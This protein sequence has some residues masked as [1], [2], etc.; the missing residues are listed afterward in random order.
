VTLNTSGIDELFAESGTDTIT[1]TLEVEINQS[2][3]P[4][5]I[6]QSEV[7]VRKDLIT[8]GSAVPAPQA[9]YLT[10]AEIAAGFV[11]SQNNVGFYGTTAI[12]KPANTNVVSALVNL[13]LIANTVTVGVASGGAANA[14][15]D[16][17]GNVS[18]TTRFLADSS[19][20]TSVDWGNRFLTD[21]SP[22][23]SLDWQNRSLKTSTAVTSV[24]WG[25][26]VLK[27]STGAT[28]VNWETGA[29]GSGSTVVTIGGNNVA[30]SGSYYIAMGTGNGAFRT[31]STTASIAF[32]SVAGNS[33]N[34]VSVTVTGCLLRDVVLLGL[35]SAVS[36][37]LS[38]IGHVTTTNGVEVDAVNATNST[39][40]Q[41]TQ[42]FR[43]TV[44]NYQ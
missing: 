38:F 42:T 6:L 31:L 36:A 13:G 17:T 4:K 40:N 1:P 3:T 2:G 23:A 8:T 34:S 22:V 12:S 32:G 7:T 25:N 16:W 30:I 5:T 19:A 15:T 24:D 14:V 10:A 9:S 39:I 27:T 11:S 18:A 33:S 20:V 44:L 21:S 41:S 35:P 28:S 37:G 26:R 29:F 43:V